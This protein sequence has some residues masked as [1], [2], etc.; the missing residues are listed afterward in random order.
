MP[1]HH[2]FAPKCH[3][4]LSI[5]TLRA[6]VNILRFALVKDSMRRCRAQGRPR[7]RAMKQKSKKQQQRR[8]EETEALG[9]GKTTSDCSNCLPMV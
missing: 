8:I 9:L 4:G 2:Y 6:Y 7:G 1:H 3:K 5:Q